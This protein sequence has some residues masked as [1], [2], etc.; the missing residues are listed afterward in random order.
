MFDHIALSVA[1]KLCS[2][3]HEFNRYKLI[4][5]IFIIL[6]FMHSEEV[7]DCEQSVTLIQSAIEYAEERHYE[8]VVGQLKNLQKSAQAFLQILKTFGRFPH[9]N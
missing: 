7:S 8:S 4:E 5:R 9:R 6:P 1:K 3:P 2:R